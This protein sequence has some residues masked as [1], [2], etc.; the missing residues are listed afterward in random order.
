M[1][2]GSSPAD[3]GL[4]VYTS[5]EGPVHCAEPLGCN[6]SVVVI[7]RHK[8]MER[9]NSKNTALVVNALNKLQK[10]E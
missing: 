7:P 5:D 4:D 3:M 1:A 9:V 6:F 10:T 2:Y 8:N